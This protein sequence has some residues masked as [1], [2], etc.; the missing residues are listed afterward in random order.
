M[1]SIHV[2]GGCHLALGGDDFKGT[3]CRRPKYKRPVKFRHNYHVPAIW[4][5]KT[6]PIGRELATKSNGASHET[7]KQKSCFMCRAQL[8]IVDGEREETNKSKLLGVQMFGK[9]YRSDGKRKLFATSSPSKKRVG[10][11]TVMA[12]VSL[13][14]NHIMHAYPNAPLHHSVAL[15]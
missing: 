4:A 11:R 9:T 15:P 7:R 3:T 10:K 14:H 8:S 2:L 1:I 13:V 6:L 12:A 5:W